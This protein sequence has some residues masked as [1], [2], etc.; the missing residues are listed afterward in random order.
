MECKWRSSLWLLSNGRESGCGGG[1]TK[2]GEGN[3]WGIYT[4]PSQE[5]KI[6][7]TSSR[8]WHQEKREKAIQF[9][10]P[11]LIHCLCPLHSCIGCIVVQVDINKKSELSLAVSLGLKSCPPSCKMRA[12]SHS[13]L[14]TKDRP[15]K[16]VAKRS[17]TAN[18]LSYEVS[19]GVLACIEHDMVNKP[20]TYHRS[21]TTHIDALSR[22]SSVDW[23]LFR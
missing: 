23:H 19:I 1:M 16:V 10:S 22:W 2:W 13:T 6:R 5:K 3:T 11:S 9:I 4:F 14:R 12:L 18:W 15:R 8:R 17:C 7:P 21:C 20:N